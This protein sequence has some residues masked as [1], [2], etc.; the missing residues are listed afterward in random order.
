MTK[1][2]RVLKLYEDDLAA[3]GLTMI[4]Y[5]IMNFSFS[6]LSSNFYGFITKIYPFAD[7]LMIR[8][9]TEIFTYILLFIVPIGL[10]S[11]SRELPEG[12]YSLFRLSAMKFILPLFFSSLF[13]FNFINIYISALFKSIGIHGLDARRTVPDGNFGKIL[14]IFSLT[15]LPALLEEM[16]FRGSILNRLRKFGNIP[17]VLVSSL[18]FAFMHFD[19]PSF[20]II[21]LMGCLFSAVTIRCNSLLP[22][23]IM[24]FLNNSIAVF[25]NYFSDSLEKKT[26]SDISFS[27]FMIQI[28][29][30]L[31]IILWIVLRFYRNRYTV[32][33][34]KVNLSKEQ[35]SQTL[36]SVA[37]SLNS[38]WMI[39]LFIL[40]IVI[41][42]LLEFKS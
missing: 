33:S 35:I 8:Q 6:L 36:K 42:L 34:S 26:L 24:H 7:I 37:D 3:I 19:I 17:A 14:F 11:M 29:S 5:V 16:L 21:F 18:I 13:F 20:I 40:S 10:M 31:I 28:I 4:I 2:R 1:R 23:V 39:L 9:I 12:Y 41:T 30:S 38:V 22:G 15:L 27:L 25:F 32:A